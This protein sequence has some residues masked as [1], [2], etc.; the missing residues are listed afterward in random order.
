MM[1]DTTTEPQVDPATQRIEANLLEHHAAEVRDLDRAAERRTTQQAALLRPDGS[2]KYAEAEHAE[3]LARI[4]AEF[5]AVAARVTEQAEAAV[6]ATKRELVLLEGADPFDRL[7]PEQQQRAALRRE[8][9]REDVEL[10]PVHQLLPMLRA[11]LV[12]GDKAE[13]WLLDRY[14]GMRIDREGG[15]VG[16]ELLMLHREL[17]AAVADPQAKAKRERL[18]RKLSAAQVLG[19]RVNLV[20]IGGVDGILAQMKASG[21]YGI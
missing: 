14:V 15:Q 11:A 16:P 17:A 21:R 20:R 6:E 7:S 4:D 8:F 3:Q 12:A 19:G 13:L 10:L 5:E 9:I 2:P 1:I 18:E